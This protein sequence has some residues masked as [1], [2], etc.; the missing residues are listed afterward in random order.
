[1]GGIVAA[2]TLLDITS[3]SPIRSQSHNNTSDLLPS[4]AA[5]T[6]QPSTLHDSPTESPTFMFPY[7]QGILAFDTPYLG[8]SPGVIA[9]GAETHYKTATTAYSTL[10]EVAGVF[11]YGA[12]SKQSSPKP[13]REDSQ[14]LLTQGA[15]AMTASL[16]ANNTDAAA[17]PTW[18]RW[19]KYAM[20]AGAAGAV[21][22]GG[23]AAYLKRDTIT[24]G[25][26]WIGSH[27]E[28]VGCLA[29]G[30]E[31]KSRLE[32]V[33]ALN[34]SRGIG[35]ANLVT[36]LG[37]AAPAQKKDGTSVA[38][39]WVEIGAVDGIAPAERTFC[40]IPKSEKNRRFFE[41]AKNDKADDEAQA[42]MTMFYPRDNPGF[43]RLGQRAK[44]L[45]VGWVEGD[46]QRWYQGSEAPG[47]ENKK[48]SIEG[49][50]VDVDLEDAEPN[51]TSPG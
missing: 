10:S 23:A 45:I 14:K 22:A 11:G 6:Q 32:R 16:N 15:D 35:F 36:V 12:S 46:A 25:W 39:G 38:G 7:V 33:V 41:K 4:T 3:D 44:E 1:M 28:F 2:E 30:E 8:I 31:L 20:F 17:I 34:K 24:E 26:T 18:Q 37:K 42:H 51:V 13:S 40:T 21:A 47:E 43:Y 50:A 5:H 29:R 49:M 27:L 48:G 9:H 19:G